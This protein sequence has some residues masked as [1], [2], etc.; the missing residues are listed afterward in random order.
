MG[1]PC[2][3]LSFVAM[4]VLLTNCSVSVVRLLF[5][6]LMLPWIND[7]RIGVA[8][9]R[10]LLGY[11][12]QAW[13]ATFLAHERCSSSPVGKTASWESELLGSINDV[14]GIRTRSGIG[15]IIVGN[16]HACCQ[17]VGLSR[18]R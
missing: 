12:E 1:R 3:E 5:P 11:A 14:H 9:A 10:S 16:T 17:H 13:G 2:H 18:R 15:T 8:G 7:L 4:F 6:I